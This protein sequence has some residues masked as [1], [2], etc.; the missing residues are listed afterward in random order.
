MFNYI[1]T[2][3]INIAIAPTAVTVETPSEIKS[4]IINSIQTLPT[5]S[6]AFVPSDFDEKY[7]KIEPFIDQYFYNKVTN[8]DVAK[9]NANAAQVKIYIFTAG[10]VAQ[11][12]KVQETLGTPYRFAFNESKR[13]AQPAT[14][15]SSA[16]MQ[17]CF[18]KTKQLQTASTGMQFNF[19]SLTSQ[20]NSQ[21]KSVE[22]SAEYSYQASMFGLD[23]ALESNANDCVAYYW[24]AI[25]ET[26]TKEIFL[27]QQPYSLN[28]NDQYIAVY[29]EKT[30]HLLLIMASASSKEI[31]EMFTV[32]NFDK[33]SRGLL[34][35]FKSMLGLVQK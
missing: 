18:I 10:E 5:S 32:S 26:S 28:N 11:S 17:I 30:G 1:F 14:L 25:A 35:Y 4:Y 23:G 29:Q 27:G 22:K 15:S 7:K 31:L 12:K 6:G 2:I 33:N 19:G 16:G 21:K 13:I 34:N 20:K 8:A 24:G 9:N 3:F